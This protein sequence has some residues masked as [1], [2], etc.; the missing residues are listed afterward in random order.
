MAYRSILAAV[1]TLL[2]IALLLRYFYIRDAHPEPRGALVRTFILGVLLVVPVIGI[3]LPLSL[4]E[5]M[6]VGPLQ[7]AAFEAFALAAIPE[8]IMKLLAILFFC[9]R[10][11]SFNEPMDG[12]VYGATVALG[13]A[14]L[15]N[16]LYVIV[17]GWTTAVARAVTAVP[18]HA[19]AGAVLGHH[20]ARARF[21]HGGRAVVWRG[22]GAAVSVHGLYD[23]GLFGAVALAA[24]RAAGG[25][26]LALAVLGLV[27]LALMALVATVIWT[28]R[29]VRRLRREQ[30]AGETGPLQIAAG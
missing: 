30:L 23:F 15:E 7:K 1:C 24:E 28:I 29:T 26:T 22:L 12:V 13:F 5:G 27:L 17:G 25:S 3:A 14:A 16:A 18:M 20:V 10:Q 6:L 4:L 11:R 2:P 8:E 19:A 21:A 9:A